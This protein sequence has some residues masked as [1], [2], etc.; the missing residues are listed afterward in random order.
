MYGTLDAA[1]RWSDDYTGHMIAA[2][3]LKGTA[4]PCH[5]Y[6]PIRSIY[7]LVHGD[8]FVLVADDDEL[9]WCEMLLKTNS[10]R[11]CVLIGPDALAVRE[12]RQRE[13][14]AADE[15]RMLQ[16]SDETPFSEKLYL[17]NYYSNKKH[18]IYTAI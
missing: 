5:F 16:G 9:T 17:F 2:G 8:D 4:S 18:S 14:R 12:A 15:Q 7:A 10:I 3:F 11:K 1:Q 13:D 6:H